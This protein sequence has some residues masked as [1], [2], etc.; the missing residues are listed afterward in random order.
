[1][2]MIEIGKKLQK[3]VEHLCNLYD[4]EDTLITAIEV[5]KNIDKETRETLKSIQDKIID[6]LY[7]IKEIVDTELEGK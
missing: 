1:M 3:K 6:D 2:F 5:D 4:I 7:F